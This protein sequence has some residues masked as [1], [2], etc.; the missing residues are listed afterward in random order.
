MSALV[1]QSPLP[2]R[3]ALRTVIEGLVGR[4]MDLVDT[5]P[6]PG[7]GSNLLGVY[8]TDRNSIAAVVVIDFEAAARL[9]GALGMLPR[10][11]IEEAI[12]KRDLFDVLR[13]NC[14]EVL[15]VVASAFNTPGAP[16][17][18]LYKVY[19]PS[20]T[21]PPDVL[22]LSSTIGSRMDITFSVAGY[23]DGCMAVIIR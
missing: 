1:E 8:V 3:H 13:E 19:G 18:R 21:V 17:V 14:Y 2:S 6:I 10:G 15:N 9:G 16:H 20:G 4:K 7:R 22:A 23:G 12:E 11:V 5:D